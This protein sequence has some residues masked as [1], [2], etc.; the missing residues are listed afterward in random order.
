[1]RI[2]RNIYFWGSLF[3]VGYS[4]SACTF[5]PSP[6]VAK[7]VD[8]PMPYEI[9]VVSA[10]PTLAQVFCEELQKAELYQQLHCSQFPGNSNIEIHIQSSIVSTSDDLWRNVRWCLMTACTVALV[11]TSAEVEYTFTFVNRGIAVRSFSL[12]SEGRIGMWGIQMAPLAI[13]GTVVGT[14]LNENKFIDKIQ[15][16]CL[17]N[18]AFNTLTNQDCQD[19]QTFLED[20]LAPIWNPFLQSITSIGNDTFRPLSKSSASM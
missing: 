13:F 11:S 5:H 6:I 16:R 7:P 17:A 2:I 9:S 14:V 19:Y 10:D 3:L 8:S 15:Q 12:R 18:P 4:L 20:S 1:M